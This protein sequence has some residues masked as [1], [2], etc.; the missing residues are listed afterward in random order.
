M[1]RM[2]TLRVGIVGAGGIAQYYHVPYFQRCKNVRVVAA[3]DVNA[4]ALE[5]MRSKFGIKKLYHDY[6]QLLEAEDLDIISICTSND[7]HYPVAMAA[8]EKGLDIYCEKPL[9]M[10]FAQAKEMYEA[11]KARGIK[12]GVNFSH[13]RTPAAQLAREIIASGALGLITYVAAVYAAGG[14]KYAEHPGSW[15]NIRE[16]AGFGGLGD[17]GAH[18]IDMMRW[19][20]DAEITAVTG[21]DPALHYREIESTLGRSFYARIDTPATPSQKAKLARLDASAVADS[22]LAGG[23]ILSKLTAAPGNGA[24]IGGLKVVTEGGWFAARPSGT[25][26]IYKLYAESFR[27]EEHLQRIIEEARALVQRVLG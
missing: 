9:A 3:C 19:W 21:R 22:Q 18:I 4:I 17:M 20:L 12:T 6:R 13:R 15:R 25:E 10:T 7:M 24:P 11:A 27:S 1:N 2:K 23:P 8:I 16:R 26:N 5:Q 14:T